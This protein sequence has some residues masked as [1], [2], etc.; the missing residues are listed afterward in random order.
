MR[1]TG[2]FL[3]KR[4]EKVALAVRRA[5]AASCSRDGASVRILRWTMDVDRETGTPCVQQQKRF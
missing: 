3:H 1:L 2:S 5:A 4:G